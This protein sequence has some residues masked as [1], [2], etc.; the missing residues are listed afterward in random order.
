M[1]LNDHEDVE[2][3]LKSAAINKFEQNSALVN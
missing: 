1:A 3:Q 2:D